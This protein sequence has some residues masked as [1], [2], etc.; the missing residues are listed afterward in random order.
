MKEL[1]TPQLLLMLI[2]LALLQ[3]SI[4]IYCAVKI[5]REGVANLSKPAWLIIV[6]VLNLVGP[7]AYL[8]VG[9]KTHDYD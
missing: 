6:L 1:L 3:T 5:I 9:R 4:A 8:L 2:P 7:I